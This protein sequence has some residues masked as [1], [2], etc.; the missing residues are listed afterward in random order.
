MING[1]TLKNRRR[2]RLFLRIWN[3]LLS[4]FHRLAV[5]W[6]GVYWDSVSRL[7]V[8]PL[9]NCK[10]RVGLLRSLLNSLPSVYKSLLRVGSWMG[11]FLMMLRDSNGILVFKVLLCRLRIIGLNLMV[12]LR[13]SRLLPLILV[14]VLSECYRINGALF[15]LIVDSS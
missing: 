1:R 7:L 6:G 12:L 10:L 3:T 9:Y 13:L 14:V 5:F 2:L 8:P 4:L 11:G 15:E